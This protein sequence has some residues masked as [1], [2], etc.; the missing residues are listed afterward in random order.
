M[1]QL[2]RI[3]NIIILNSSFI[4]NIGINE[5][6]SSAIFFYSLHEKTQNPYY[7]NIAEKLIDQIRTSL[8]IHMPVNFTT[9]LSGIG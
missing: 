4:P 6:S 5:K 7:L 8:N 3:T 2:E 1:T 9:G